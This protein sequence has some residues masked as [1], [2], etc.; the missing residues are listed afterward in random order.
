L[1]FK[2]KVRSLSGPIFLTVALLSCLLILAGRAQALLQINQV[3]LADDYEDQNLTNR[4]GGW[5][6]GDEEF[7]GGCV[8]RFVTD[9]EAFGNAGASLALDYD[10][11]EPGSFS[12]FWS[13]LGKGDTVAGTSEGVNLAEMRYLS[14]WM[15]A[16]VKVG[17]P[18]LE[19]FVELHEDTN[20]DRRFTLGDDTKD[21]VPASRFGVAANA[22]GWQKV[23]IPL[24]RFRKIGHWD[25]VLEIVFV[26]ESKW[27]SG[28]GTLYL[29]D[30]LFGANYPDDLQPGAE[31]AMQNRV[32]SFKINGKVVSGEAKVKRKKPTTLALTLIFVDPYLEEVRFEKSSD[33][34]NTWRRVKSFFDHSTAGVYE[35]EVNWGVDSEAKKSEKGIQFRVVG[36]SFQGGENQLAGPYRFSFD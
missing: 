23:V 9:D 18:K 6:Q 7:P 28:T 15:K 3:I 17:T 36:L 1:S 32:S 33:G 21:R 20:G 8:P 22:Q 14:F 27:K 12:Y 34:G 31:I 16:G 4:F 29:D 19:F 30:V 10:V 26:F 2:N 13:K 35:G 25:Q 24:S 11:K 5:S